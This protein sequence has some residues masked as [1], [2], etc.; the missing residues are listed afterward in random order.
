M[1]DLSTPQWPTA[2]RGRLPG[3]RLL[4]VDGSMWLYRRCPM[5]PMADA[6]SPEAA[7]ASAAPLRMVLEELAALGSGRVARRAVARSR[8]R[9]VHILSLDVPAWYRPPPG[10]A[11]REHLARSFAGA[12][13]RRRLTLVGVKLTARLTG[14]GLSRAVA[15]VA[16]TLAVAGTPVEDFEADYRRVD[17]VMA[18]AGMAVPTPEEIWLADSWWDAGRRPDVGLLEHAD[19]L[20]VFSEPAAMAA[21][22]SL[23]EDCLQWADVPGQHSLSFYAAANFDLPFVEETEPAARWAPVLFDM[24]V[25]AVSLRGLLEPP[26]VTRSELRRVR[27]QYLDDLAERV[28]QGKMSRAEQEETLTALTDM[29]ALYATGGPGTLTDASMVVALS[30]QDRDGRLPAAARDLGFELLPMTNRQRRALAECWVTSHVRANPHLEDLPTHVVSSSGLTS[31]STV[32]DQTG[33]LLGFTERDRQPAY[34][35]PSGAAD[36]DSVPVMVVAGQSGSGKRLIL[37]TRIPTPT[38]WTTIGNLALRDW[39]FGRNGQPCRVVFLSDITQKPDLYRVRFDDGQEVYADAEHQWLVASLYNRA[40]ARHPKHMAAIDNWHRSQRNIATLEA[41]AGELGDRLVGIKELLRLLRERLERPPWAT[42][43]SLRSAL[44]CAGCR[45]E[46]GSELGARE[47]DGRRLE[48]TDPVVLFPVAATLR[49]CLAA[50]EGTTGSNAS[51][52]GDRIAAKVAA[53]RRL[54]ATTDE[55][56]EATA[57]DIARRLAAAGAPM[58]KG[59]NALVATYARR[60]GVEGRRGTA[61]V[62]VPLPKGPR[63]V[64]KKAARYVASVALKALAERLRQQAG[65]EPATEA[66]ERVVTTAQMLAEGVVVPTCHGGANF[67]VRVPE[68]LNLPDADLPV[69]PYVLGA[70]LGDGSRRSGGFTGIDREI[71]SEIQRTGYKVSDSTHAAKSQYIQGLVR[72]LRFA[73]VLDRKHI[74]AGDDGRL[75]PVNYLRASARQRL[76]LLQGLMDT[77]GTVSKSGSCELSLCDERLA[78][79]ALELIRSLGIKATVA[80]SQATITEADPARPGA[81]RRRATGTRWRIRFTTDKPVFRLPRKASRLPAKVRETQRWLYVTSIEPVEPEPARCIQVDSADSTYLVEGFVPTHNTVAMVHLAV[82]FAQI[83]TAKGERTPTII[84]DPKTGSDLGPVVRAAGGQVASLDDLVTGDGIFDPL[85]FAASPV[86]AQDLATNLLLAINPWGRARADFEAPLASAIGYGVQAG[87]TCIG[88]ALELALQAGEASPALARP[89]AELAKVS[90]LVRACIGRE[91]G[92][93]GLRAAEGLTLIRVGDTYLDLTPSAEPTLNQRVAA[94]LVRM[95]VFGSAM[96]LSG[97][98]GV[99]MVD[100]AWVVLQA[101][102]AEVERLGRVARSQ[103]V[104]PVLFTQRVTDAVKAGMSGYISR[105][106]IMAFTDPEE[107][108]AGCELFRLE[109]TPERLER[110]LAKDTIGDGTEQ[111]P[112]WA[113]MRALRDGPGGR[114]LR[115]SLAIYV[116]LAGRAVLTEVAIPDEVLRLA[117]TNPEDIRRRRSA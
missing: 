88:E 116:D 81:K 73:G 58:P 63:V 59:S 76:A 64:G 61:R 19:H 101:G 39:V 68:P 93:T 56:E 48:K 10:H 82:Q 2:K 5:G 115:G 21:A 107:A 71:I 6:R 114:V 7:M 84:L 105:G 97:R 45:P 34:I 35:S 27:K 94:A 37:T 89:V 33:A 109:P 72:H 92:T 47:Y 12:Q 78:Q 113:S 104:F 24:G 38:G 85:R 1:S 36:V 42:V 60:A 87:A 51:R 30:G 57:A 66:A 103:E 86:V 108:R 52:W 14:G 25:V 111:A 16:E 28:A 43:A 8:Y 46:L 99:L 102:L 9:A 98:Q 44:W 75:F 55:D 31:L 23:P 54:L 90:P 96:A 29:E 4:G 65:S 11:L 83:P 17:D 41:L 117:S 95:M 20:H 32:G 49:A 74:P 70:W 40:G 69:D 13:V 26:A 80:A 100:E 112:N 67:A 77:D 53:A 79:D 15:S 110:M 3:G 18:R 50:W 91:P 62:V 22:E 106:L